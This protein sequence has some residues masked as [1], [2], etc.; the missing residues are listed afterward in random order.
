VTYGDCIVAALGAIRA[1][2]LR[3]VLTALGIIIGV[4]AVIV[5]I[6]V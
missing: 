5:M 2:V 6:S 3:S 4:A 1:N